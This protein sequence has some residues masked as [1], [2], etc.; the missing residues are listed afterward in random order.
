M[1]LSQWRNVLPQCVLMKYK[2]KIP[3]SG[4]AL[5]RMFNLVVFSSFLFYAC[6]EHSPSVQTPKVDE[7]DS[8]KAAPLAIAQAIKNKFPNAVPYKDG[9]DTVVSYLNQ[10]GIPAGSILWGQSTCVDDI[11][12]TK[13]KLIPE[14]KGP[15]NFGGLAGLPFTGVTGLSAFAHHVPEDGTA[16][17]FVVPHI[18]YNEKEGWGKILRHDQHHASSC[19]GALAAALAK[20]KNAELK[21]QPPSQQDYQENIIEQ[22]AYAHRNEILSS[23]EPILSFTRVIYHKAMKQMTDYVAK[24]KERHFKYAVVVRGVIINTDYTFPDYLWIERVSILDVEKNL[25]VEA[26]K[27]SAGVT[28]N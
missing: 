28:A 18:G 27:P 4:I 2:N 14:I 3:L 16:L 17:L 23:Q 21:S 9:I 20:L 22:L 12:N 24:I 8:V 26:E 13:N 7:T 1:S 10:F 19:C 11:T 15:F 25:W 5:I 6:S